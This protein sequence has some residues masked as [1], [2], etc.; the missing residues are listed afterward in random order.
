MIYLTGNASQLVGSWAESDFLGW[1]FSFQSL[2]QFVPHPVPLPLSLLPFLHRIKTEESLKKW[3]IICIIK[4]HSAIRVLKYIFCF[5]CCQTQFFIGYAAEKKAQFTKQFPFE[6]E[7]YCR[8]S[9][10]ILY[11]FILC[12]AWNVWVTIWPFKHKCDMNKYSP[13]CALKDVRTY[14]L[15]R[16]LIRQ[17]FY[18]QAPW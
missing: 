6:F 2:E 4:L 10:L 17:T 11:L 12:F 9:Y 15:Y 1:H 8:G 5:L 13:K 18:W 7:K 16:L 3:K 14:V